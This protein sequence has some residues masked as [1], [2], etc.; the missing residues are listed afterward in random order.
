MKEIINQDEYK[1]KL[2][3]FQNITSIEEKEKEVKK[4]SGYIKAYTISFL[5]PPLGLYYFIKYIFFADGE[6]EDIRAGVISLVLTLISVFL[7]IW[8][9]KYYLDQINAMIPKQQ[10]Q[11]LLNSF[12][13]L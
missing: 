2:E 1:K 7:T 5:I 13:N 11:D 12:G 8:S 9:V 10:G 6:P 3:A 4:K